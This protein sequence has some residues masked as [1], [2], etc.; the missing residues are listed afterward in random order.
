MVHMLPLIQED[1]M[2]ETVGMKDLFRKDLTIV[3]EVIDPESA[4]VTRQEDVYVSVAGVAMELALDVFPEATM[5]VAQCDI[6]C[7]EVISEL[8]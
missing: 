3:M 5:A 1:G 6:V 2:S 4:E 8:T 7:A